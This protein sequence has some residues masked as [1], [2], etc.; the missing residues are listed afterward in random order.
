MRQKRLQSGL[1]PD[2][3]SARRAARLTQVDVAAT[4]GLSLPS[5]RQA[6]RGLGE[7]AGYMALAAAVSHRIGGQSLPPGE[8]LGEQLSS[9][10]K[11]RRWGRRILA[12]V[13]GVSPTTIAALERGA[14]VRVGTAVRVAEALGVRLRLV[15][16]GTPMSFWSAA[17]NSS[18][19]HGWETPPNLLDDLYQVVGSGFDL[20]PCSPTRR[21]PVRARLRYTAADNGLE[22]PWRGKVFVNPPYGR[23][24]SSWIAKGRAE[25]E[26]GRASLVVA[27]VPARTDTRWWHDHVAARADV[28]LLR[29]RLSFGDGLQ[30]APF[31]SAIVVWGAD[32][33]LQ[34]IVPHCVV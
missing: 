5:I 30:A 4:V 1:G 2:L 22:L 11:R 34:R 24:L 27:L 10:R 23:Q 9:M 8:C 18:A 28:W 21:G 33:L 20:D 31:P 14:S 15:P 29:G 25:A 3:R 6:E 17:G 32:N 12:D 16:V 13:A 26:A 7:M 19:H